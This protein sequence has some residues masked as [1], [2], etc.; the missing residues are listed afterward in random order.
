MTGSC[1]TTPPLRLYFIVR[2]GIVT[3]LSYGPNERE[4]AK[5]EIH[6]I[7]YKLV[8]GVLAEDNRF[9]KFHAVMSGIWD[10]IRGAAGGLLS[11]P[12]TTAE[13]ERAT[14]NQRSGASTES[15][16]YMSQHR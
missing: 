6:R 4:W 14:Y 7:M 5:G 10:G 2:N 1:S 13:L 12:F 16:S 8:M 15:S 3:L 9:R 11:F